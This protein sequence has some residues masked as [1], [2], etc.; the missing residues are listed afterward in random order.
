MSS[1]SSN[2]ARECT[3]LTPMCC[4]DTFLSDRAARV[5]IRLHSDDVD[6]YHVYDTVLHFNL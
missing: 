6:L 5:Y 4:T 3:S 1:D 2:S